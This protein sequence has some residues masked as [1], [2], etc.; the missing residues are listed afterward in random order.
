METPSPTEHIYKTPIYTR[1]ARMAYYYREKA[2][3]SE[4]LKKENERNNA[5]A[6][7]K[8]QALKDIKNEITS[9]MLINI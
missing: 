1:N 6:K 7:L 5:R 2:K 3:G 8:R 9:I 4:Y